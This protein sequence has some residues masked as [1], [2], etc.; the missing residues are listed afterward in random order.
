MA[1]LN[2]QMVILVAGY[3][4]LWELRKKALW[5]CEKCT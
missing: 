1:M 5:K 3:G 4:R 2:N